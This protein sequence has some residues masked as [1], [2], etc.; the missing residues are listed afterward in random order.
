MM[1]RCRVLRFLAIADSRV[2]GLQAMPSRTQ[3]AVS[4]FWRAS[5]R[6]KAGLCAAAASAGFFGYLGVVTALHVLTR[7]SMDAEFDPTVAGTVHRSWDD[8]EPE[9]LPGDVLLLMGASQMSWQICNAQFFHSILRPAAIR[10][11]HVALVVAAKKPA[12]VDPATGKVLQPGHGALIYEVM[13]NTDCYIT[14]FMTKTVRTMC[15]Q[16]VEAK[17]RIFALDTVHQKPCY[18]R[19]GIRKL[20]RLTGD[21]IPEFVKSSQ[22]PLYRRHCAK[23]GEGHRPALSQAQVGELWRFIAAHDHYGM[24]DSAKV[25]LAFVHPKLFWLSDLID[26]RRSEMTT[27]SELLTKL[28]LSLGVAE[29]NNSNTGRRIRYRSVAPYQFGSGFEDGIGLTGDFHLGSEERIPIAHDASLIRSVFV[30]SDG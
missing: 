14:D 24:D 26:H 4:R 23:N 7:P 25:M 13:D 18:S 29:V 12:E 22:R 27:C 6:R 19:L 8:V 9:L 21:D 15:P 16:I 20:Y 11:S 28:L 2:T 5:R 1:R 3:A 10:Y 17:D 30:D